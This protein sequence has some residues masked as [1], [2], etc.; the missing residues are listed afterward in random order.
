MRRASDT[1]AL[2]ERAP[3]SGPAAGTAPAR[4]LLVG[5]GLGLG[6][7]EQLLLAQVRGG[8]TG[9]FSYSV[10]Y[11]NSDKDALVADFE[12][13]GVPVHCLSSGPLP[14]PVALRSLLAKEHFHIVHAHSPLVASVVRVAART[15][16]DGPLLVYTEHNSWAPYGM[17][18]RWANRVTYRLDD[19][20]FAVSRAAWDSV[21]VGLRSK[22]AVLSHGIDV[23]AVGRHRE[24]REQSRRELGIAP[25]EVVIGTVANFRPEKNYEGLLRAAR[26]VTASDPSV[27][28]VSIGQGPLQPEIEHLHASMGLGERFLILGAQPEAPRLMAAFDVFVLASHVEGLPV[29]FMEARALGLPVVVTAVGGL[30]DHVCD[31]TDGL[32]VAPGSDDELVA[33]LERLT[34]SAELRHRIAAGSAA[35]A[36]DVD[37]SRAIS[38]VEQAYLDILEGR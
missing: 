14:W 27:R 22:L 15:M 6:G 2:E 28:F 36:G 16:R 9:R 20:Q 13:L 12:S 10:A 21:P 35:G 7:M 4:V 32:L 37:A 33:A 8:D 25:D 31:G 18:T 19:T 11:V 5:R 29:A 30:P 23:E 34:G 17:P 26:R 24:Q 3:G 1:G 38:V